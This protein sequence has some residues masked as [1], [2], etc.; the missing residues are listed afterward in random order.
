L[1]NVLVPLGT[2][3]ADIFGP[4]FEKLSVVLTDLWNNVV[5]P[6]AGAVGSV[7]AVAFDALADTFNWVTEQIEP[8]LKILNQVWNDTLKPMADFVWDVFYPVFEEAFT[9]IGELIGDIGE[10]FSGLIEFVSGVFTGNWKNAW[11]GIKDIFTGIWDTLEDVVR[12]PLNAVLALFEGVA[13]GIIDAWNYIKE[14]INSIS[15]D[16]PDWVPSWAGGGSHFGFNLEMSSHVSIPRFE[17]GGYPDKAS[18]FWA[19]ENGVP[20]MLGT[21]G[22]KT[23]VAGG[24]EITG[25]REEIRSTAD[26]EI[27]LLRQQN[28]LLQA[29]LQKEFGITQNDI[30]KSARNYA[31]EYFDRTGKPAYV[32]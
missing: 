2:F 5:V 18:L 16:I 1:N 28:Q 10:I 32:F 21:V 3:L 8:M 26:E 6:L 14:S 12:S 27:A 7:L 19:G 31:K 30:G 29:I 24:E 4:I 9:L 17:I 20:E 23:A 11:T 22:G 13:N 15:F 25:I